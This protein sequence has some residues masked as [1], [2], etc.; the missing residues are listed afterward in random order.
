MDKTRITDLVVFRPL[1]TGV[2]VELNYKMK[3]FG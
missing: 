2:A 1:G 3:L